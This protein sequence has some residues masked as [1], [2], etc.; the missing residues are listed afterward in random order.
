MA[1]PRPAVD[2]WA[3]WRGPLSIAVVFAFLTAF[4]TWPQAL[5][6]KTHALEHQDVFFNLWRL[7]WVAHALSTSPLDL[8]NANVFHPERGVLAYRTPCSSRG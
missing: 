7:C 4:M 2:R 8:F 1:E 3:F 6:M 5:V